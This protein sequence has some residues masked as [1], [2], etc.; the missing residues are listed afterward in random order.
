[1]LD[2][3]APV[4][5][6]SAGA[7]SVAAVYRHRPKQATTGP[8]LALGTAYLKWYEVAPAEQ[9]APATIRALARGFLRRQADEGSLG[10]GGEIGFVILHRC[11]EEFYFLLLGTWRNENELW[12]SVYA[13]TSARSVDF[14]PFTFE[15]PHRG[16][17]CV[18]ELGAVWH[19][20]Q[21]WLRYLESKRDAAAREAYAAD[22]Y[23]GPV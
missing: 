20:R 1:M 11:S 2:A 18:W 17:F 3:P 8:G 23:E 5:P 12:E 13:R 16:T 4:V 9:P 22:Q 14:E 15:G 19:E 6:P 7:A 10:V 21:A